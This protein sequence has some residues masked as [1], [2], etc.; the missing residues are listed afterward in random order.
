M[1]STAATGSRRWLLR[2]GL[3]GIAMRAFPAGFEV[4]RL[5]GAAAASGVSHKAIYRADAVVTLFS[6]T[7][8]SRSNV[9][10][11]FATICECQEPG[12]LV[13]TL[14]FGGG[15]VPGRARG[16]N[17]L[18]YI[19]EVV[20]ERDGAPHEA[21]YFGFITSNTEETVEQARKTLI[22][23]GP[24][25]PYI[26][27]DAHAVAGSTRSVLAK[28]FVPSSFT[29]EQFKPLSTWIRDR[30][31]STVSETRDA[32]ALPRTFLYAIRGVMRDPASRVDTGY[33][34][35]GN[36]YAMHVEKNLDARGSIRYKGEVRNLATGKTT[37]FKFWVEHGAAL[38]RRIEMQVR[39]YLK[40]AF[41]TDSNATDQS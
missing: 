35:N 41:D 19:Q 27:V 4:D 3:A 24:V 34:Y 36:Q 26:A 28:L 6:V 16:L 37:P 32:E 23:T 1:I 31:Q 17:R 2:L 13:L 33:F 29:W 40:I 8:F 39:S 22:A 7:V 30:F 38:P 15:S 18:G 9:G 14:R 20:V 21:A 12:R 25:A 5:L 11:G 10:S